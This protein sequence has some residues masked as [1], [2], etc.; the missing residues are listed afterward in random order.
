[1]PLLEFWKSSPDAVGKLNVEQ[2]VSSAGDGVIKDDSPCSHE[3]REFLS[4]IPSARIAAYVE[5]CLATSFAKGGWVLQ[6]LVN[7]LGRRL[8]YKVQNGRYSGTTNA[9]GFDGLWQSQ[10][11]HSIIIEVK[12]TDAYRISLD[13]SALFIMGSNDLTLTAACR[14]FQRAGRPLPSGFG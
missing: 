8:D 10:E 2:V 4:Q 5:H 6:D 3:L 11:D 7:E 13:G 14:V 1:M 12:T 9:I